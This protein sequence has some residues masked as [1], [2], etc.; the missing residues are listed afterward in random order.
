[1]GEVLE[2]YLPPV[3]PAEKEEACN[4]SIKTNV[5]QNFFCI[6]H[7]LYIF[8]WHFVFCNFFGIFFSIFQLNLQETWCIPFGFLSDHC[9]T[10]P[11]ATIMQ[12]RPVDVD[13]VAKIGSMYKSP[14]VMHQLWFSWVITS[15][16]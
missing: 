8:F 9:S 16:N 2:P 13:T 15:L 3:I 10:P 14:R 11:Q 12:G 1:M 7:I 6:F 5:F 4:M